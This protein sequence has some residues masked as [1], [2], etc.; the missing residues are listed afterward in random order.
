M[1]KPRS[2]L[3][4][5]R[6]SA[7]TLVELLVVIAVI[8]ILIGTIGLALRPGSPAVALRGAQGQVQA[9][10]SQ[11]RGQAQL[12]GRPVR[13][14]VC[15][16]RNDPDRYLKF[17]GI[18]YQPDPPNGPWLAATAGTTLQGRIYVVPETVGSDQLGAE[19]GP[20]PDN[21][22]SSFSGTENLRYE[23]PTEQE[24][25]YIE[26]STRG[27]VARGSNLRIALAEGQIGAEGLGPN[28]Q[29]EFVNPDNVMGVLIRPY[30]V[31][32]L[33]NE[34]AAFPPS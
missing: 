12:Q 31:P 17:M 34:P 20:W 15:V 1:S 7:F 8:G 11:T 4:L 23:S 6:P 10:V 18:V 19:V 13:L 25:A 24:F 2:H 16:D 29:I 9:L 26:F 30:G 3:S 33:L 27:T 5:S 21:L 32:V 22:V 28:F 14:V